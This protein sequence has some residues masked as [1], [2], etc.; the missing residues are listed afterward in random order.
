MA[1]VGSKL[2]PHIDLRERCS[3]SA[4]DFSKETK[5]LTALQ[6]VNSSTGD[7][8]KHPTPESGWRYFR[9]LFVVLKHLV[10]LFCLPGDMAEE[11][12]Q[13]NGLPLKKWIQSCRRPR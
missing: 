1:A 8:D 7:V 12:A 6:H 11:Y 13:L 9:S 2:L 3:T 5:Q 10:Y 4:V